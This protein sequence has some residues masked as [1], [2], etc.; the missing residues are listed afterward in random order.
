MQGDGEE[1]SQ[2]TAGNF[3]QG[4]QQNMLRP[5][6]TFSL[7]VPNPRLSSTYSRSSRD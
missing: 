7:Q 4:A 2:D 5:A 6:L 3:V 1:A